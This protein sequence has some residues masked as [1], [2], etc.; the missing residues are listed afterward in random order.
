[1]TPYMTTRYR[2]KKEHMFYKTPSPKP[3]LLLLLMVMGTTG[4]WGATI[5]FNLPNGY[6]FL[7][8]DAGDNDVPKYNASSFEANFYMCPAYSATVNEQNYLGGDGS[9]PLITTFKSFSF[10]NGKT[11][12]HAIWYIEAA[13][14]SGNEGYF[15]IKHYESGQ[16]MVA[17]DNTSP[18]TN[19]RRV[20]LGP[21]ANP[22]NDGMFK[23]QSDDGGDTYYITSRT[24]YDTTT[25]ANKYLSPSAGDKNNLNATS[26]NSNTGGILGFWKGNNLNSAW[27]FVIAQCI[28]PDITGYN[29]TTNEVTMGSDTPGVTIYYTTDGTPPT[30]SSSQYNPSSKPTISSTTT[31]KAIAV[32]ENRMVDSEV[33][34]ITL[35]PSPTITLTIPEG[36]FVTDGTAIEPT[37]SVED[38]GTPIDPSE[39]E[40][41]YTNNT[42]AGTATVTITDKPGGS[43]YVNEVSQNF[44]I[45][46]SIGDGTKTSEGI[47]ITITKTTDPETTTVSVTDEGDALTLGTDY[48]WAPDEDNPDI[49]IVTGMGDFYSGSAKALY[50]NAV[51]ANTDVNEFTAA[52]QSSLD[53]VPPS[54]VTVYV[55]KKVNPSVGTVTITPI[56]YMPAD[57][58]VLL[59]AESDLSGFSTSPLTGGTTPVSDDLLSGNKLML[60]PEGGTPVE[61]TEAY[62]FY[63]G[64][65]VLTQAGTIKKGNFFIYNPNYTETPAP[66]PPSPSRR[67]LRMVVEEEETGIDLGSEELRMKN[68]E[69]ATAKNWY[70]IEGI[71][72]GS[73]PTR[74]G[75]YLHNGKKV[76]IR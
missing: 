27:H 74:K 25:P 58:P 44:Y 32:R 42:S 49:I 12:L 20:N 10:E 38:S 53:V 71:K 61:S 50:A 7:G 73:K 70:T 17:N 4:A 6:Y 33:G 56:S 69:F 52:Y 13:T 18:S 43:Y 31:V 68:E 46:K 64:E 15:Y 39:Y 63:L 75:L 45:A 67:Y 30:T 37:V 1:M 66:V 16:Y 57:V 26:D 22:G 62:M 48:T 47:V 60:A 14:G 55:V 23:I 28:I 21:T 36:G 51:F 19:R 2:H 8:N 65:F 54:E 72:L 41:T 24:K 35:V 29:S 40:V 76:I 11:Y 5:D 59:M 34:T 3:F 9:K